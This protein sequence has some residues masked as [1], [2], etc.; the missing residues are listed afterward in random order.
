MKLHVEWW[1][2]EDPVILNPQW[3]AASSTETV[4]ELPYVRCVLSDYTALRSERAK[5]YRLL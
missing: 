2:I 3:S 5:I 1:I 4:Q